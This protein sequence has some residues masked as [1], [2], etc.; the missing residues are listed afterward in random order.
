[1]TLNLSEKLLS[2]AEHLNE[3]NLSG[4]VKGNKSHEYGYAKIYQVKPGCSFWIHHWNDDR[5]LIDLL[6]SE[7]AKDRY[8]LE[9]KETEKIFK[10]L[11]FENVEN[12]VWRHSDGKGQKHD[13][14]YIDVGNDKIED[15]KTKISKIK[16]SFA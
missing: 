10:E 14:Y 16:K 1:M 5:L 2:I 4:K 7:T 8:P 15:I 9:S 13:H 3:L 6:I 12:T 11:F